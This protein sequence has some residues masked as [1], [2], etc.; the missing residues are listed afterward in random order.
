MRKAGFSLFI[1][2]VFLIAGISLVI[3]G[4]LSGLELLDS[5]IFSFLIPLMRECGLR[6]GKWALIAPGVLLLLEG[7]LVFAFRLRN[8]S[9]WFRIRANA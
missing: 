9:R 8:W 1:A 7:I 5:G 3:L 4:V 2:W 6:E